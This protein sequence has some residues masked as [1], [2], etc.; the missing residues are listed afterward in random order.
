MLSVNLYLSGTIIIIERS[1]AGGPH[2]HIPGLHHSV[3]V[4]VRIIHH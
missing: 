4:Q 1:S 3:G 2:V